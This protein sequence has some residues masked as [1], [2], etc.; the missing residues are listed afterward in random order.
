MKKML[1]KIASALSAAA[2]LT[3]AGCSQ[4]PDFNVSSEID[5]VLNLA[6]PEVNVTAY[7]GMNYVSWTPVA[8]AKEYYLY[9]SIDGHQVSTQT[10]SASSALRYVD[11]SVKANA[12]Y[13]YR[14]EATS[15]TS[16]GRAVVTENAMSSSVSI[17]SIVPDYDTKPLDLYKFESGSKDEKYIVSASNIKAFLDDKAKIGITF[18]FI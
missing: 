9:T 8:N 18:K 11:K 12:T 17:K 15:K 2:I 13:T 7:P 3:L 14:V 16:T 4:T 10:V 1:V 5:T 6:K